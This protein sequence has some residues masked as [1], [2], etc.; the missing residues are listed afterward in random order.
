MKAEW[1]G[2]GGNHPSEDMR[3][4]R[5]P[6]GWLYQVWMTS[7]TEVMSDSE[8]NRFTEGWSQPVFVAEVAA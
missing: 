1:E 5:V 8:P 4:T 3:R 6:G 2:I 7:N